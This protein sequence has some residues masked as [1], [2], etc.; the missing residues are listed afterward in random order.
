M[1]DKRIAPL[2]GNQVWD[3]STAVRILLFNSKGSNCKI[4]K[5][6]PFKDWD[7]TALF[8]AILYAQTFALPDPVTPSTKKTLH[9]LFLI[10]PR[11]PLPADSFHL[12]V[13]SPSGDK[14]ETIALA[15]DQLRRL[16][17]TICHSTSSLLEKVKFD[18]YV[19]YAKE[20]FTAVN[21]STKS[22]E[23]IG[24]LDESHFPTAKVKELTERLQSKE[25]N[26]ENIKET[27][28]EIKKKLDKLLLKQ[29]T[30]GML[31]S[32]LLLQNQRFF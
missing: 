25:N 21:L 13:A 10:N 16:R 32:F 14:N 4:S 20:A 23:T 9:K 8:Q 6:K 31:P 29:E 24:N 2:H 1:W 12:S 28:D 5:N 18:D 19:K 26:L 7:C 15:I 27:T 30:K 11:V 3:D 17:N 22:L